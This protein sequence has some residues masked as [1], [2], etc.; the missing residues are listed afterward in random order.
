MYA[1]EPRENVQRAVQAAL[2]ELS[3]QCVQLLTT[4]VSKP[5]TDQAVHEIRTRIKRMRALLRLV[6]ADIGHARY[7]QARRKLKQTSHSLANV[8]D[9][10]V[11]LTTC[12]QL[13][14]RRTPS[15]RAAY[16]ISL[17][18]RLRAARGRFSP[19]TRRSMALK[20]MTIQKVVASWPGS[21][22]GW[23]VLSRGLRHEYANTR[24]AF[25][26]ARQAPSDAHLH[27]LRK[28]SKRLLYMCE[29][30]GTLSASAH[31]EARQLKRFAAYLG[32]VHDLSVLMSAVPSAQIARLAHQKQSALR[33]KGWTLGARIF[34]ESP[35]KFTKRVHKEWRKL[36]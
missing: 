23:K 17:R 25:E 5:L 29:F 36:R 6:R 13:L 31:S 33:Q 10:K 28:R 16:S 20:L 3:Q 7:E 1:L 14:R 4:A 34:S 11:M 26:A 15:Y 32:A 24:D 30:L 21:D 35:A 12:Q 9:A 18:R 22:A 27:E 8:R 2:T 19:R